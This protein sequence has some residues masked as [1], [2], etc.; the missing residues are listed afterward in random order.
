MSIWKI[1]HRRFSKSGIYIFTFLFINSHNNFKKIFTNHD[2]PL[3]VLWFRFQSITDDK[4]GN[5]FHLQI[6]STTQKLSQK[7]VVVVCLFVL[8]FFF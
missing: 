8:F 7:Y 6:A 5:S 1:T 4:I 2:L 3:H